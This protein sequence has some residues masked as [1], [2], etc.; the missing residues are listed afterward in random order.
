MSAALQSVV[1]MALDLVS[2]TTAVPRTQNPV[3]TAAGQSG[4]VTLPG[5]VAS[6]SSQARPTATVATSASLLSV[7]VMGM[8]PPAMDNATIGRVDHRRNHTTTDD[9]GRALD[10]VRWRRA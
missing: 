7:R 1:A 9:Q 4:N 2:P 6:S 5:P 3:T 8:R 10:V